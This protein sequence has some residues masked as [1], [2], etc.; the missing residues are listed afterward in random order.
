M[1]FSFDEGAAGEGALRLELERLKKKLAAEGLFD[2]SQ[3]RPLPA[4]PGQVGLITSPTGAAIRDLLSVLGRRFP[5]L[6]VLGRS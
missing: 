3:K 1:A 6:R 2:D 5:A 4:I